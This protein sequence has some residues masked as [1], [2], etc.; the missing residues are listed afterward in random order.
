MEWNFK[1]GIPIYAQIVEEL[2]MRI[3]SGAYAPGDKLPSVRDLAMDAGVNPNTMQRALAE[4]ERRGL[5]FSER[6]SGRF[7]TKDEDVLRQLHAKLAGE[8]FT[9]LSEKLSKIGMSSDEVKE[10]LDRWLSQYDR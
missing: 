4:L 10:A 8:Y 2:T 7:V 9:E 5:V 1:N 6:T 3:A